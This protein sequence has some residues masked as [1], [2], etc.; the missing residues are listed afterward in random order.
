MQRGEFE[1]VVAAAKRPRTC[2]LQG[3]RWLHEVTRKA[4]AAG[5]GWQVSLG[6]QGPSFGVFEGGE[7]KGSCRKPQP[8]FGVVLWRRS[9]KEVIIASLSKIS[10][11][12]VSV[13]S[14]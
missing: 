11:S 3:L 14:F 13:C 4:G 6:W 12:T 7:P 1:D 8:C 5:A 10:A 2:P 9:T